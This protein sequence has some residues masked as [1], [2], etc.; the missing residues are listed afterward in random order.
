M[1]TLIKLSAQNEPVGA[2][3]ERD[4]THIVNT[5]NILTQQIVNCQPI[6]AQVLDEVSNL[7]ANQSIANEQLSESINKCWTLA[8]SLFNESDKRH[9][10]NEEDLNLVDGKISQIDSLE[11]CSS[12][13]HTKNSERGMYTAHKKFPSDSDVGYG[14]TE[15]EHTRRNIRSPKE[16]Q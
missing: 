3:L 6:T 9:T 7:N 1:G 11:P 8:S 12:S 16:S 10:N 14:S 13:R 4:V 15:K 5:N 2:D